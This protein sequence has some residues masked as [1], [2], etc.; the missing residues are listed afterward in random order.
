MKY[1]VTTEAEAEVR[2]CL[3]IVNQSRSVDRDTG[4]R[5][6]AVDEMAAGVALLRRSIFSFLASAV[7]KTNLGVGEGNWLASL[8]SAVAGC[9]L[10]EPVEGAAVVHSGIAAL[11]VQGH[12]QLGKVTNRVVCTV[13]IVFW[14]TVVSVVLVVVEL[15]IPTGGLVDGGEV[16]LLHVPLVPHQ[17]HQL[18][19][20]SLAE[21]D[22]E[23]EEERAEKFSAPHCRA[24]P[25]ASATPQVSPHCSYQPTSSSAG[26]VSA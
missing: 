1:I 13:I 21:A 25:E 16:V 19:L 4:F 12:V 24:D 14:V 9:D 5:E 18:Q 2:E 8:V 17:A 22:K 10:D 26:N 7:V 11:L 3:P 20:P 6:K 23:E 15:D